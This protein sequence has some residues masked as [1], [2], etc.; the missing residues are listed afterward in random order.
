MY[1]VEGLLLTVLFLTCAYSS[2]TDIKYG[3]IPNKILLIAGLL[4]GL[5]NLL[6][7]SFW[8][9]EYFVV[10]AI[11][12]MILVL[13][14]VAMYAFN[15]WAAGDS[16]LLFLVVFAIPSRLYDTGA[17]IAPAIFIIVF[18]F[19]IS[20]LYVVLES[21]VIRIKSGDKIQFP[22]TNSVFEFVKNYAYIL[23]YLTA[24]NYLL[25]Y[26][27]PSFV[28]QNSSLVAIGGLLLSIA[29]YK[30]P[31]F[32]NRLI[33]LTVAILDAVIITIYGLH[34]G[35]SAPNL[36]TYLYV[37]AVLFLRSISEKYNYLVIP[38]SSVKPGMILSFSTVAAM[39]ASR[40]HGL[41]KSTT[42]DMRSRISQ[43]EA[44]SIIRWQ[45][46]KYGMA[47]ITIVR[48]IPFA[49]FMTLGLLVFLLLRWGMT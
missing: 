14:S 38:T 3:I 20:F 32:Y 42:E 36:R 21:L 34:Y 47:E 30:Y 13:L 37:A 6:Y 29:I 2:I 46:S 10:F 41:P 45:N 16:K 8:G 48:K 5:L 44:D 9:R 33:V 12:F 23:L 15:L 39:S 18:T 25:L 7:Y 49:I 17:G 40:V 35:F 28:R 1:I 31:I 4:S 27:F 24:V 11:D 19:S 26:L 22:S 43:E